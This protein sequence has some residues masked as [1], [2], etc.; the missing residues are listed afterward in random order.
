VAVKPNFS[1]P[2]RKAVTQTASCPVCGKAY[3]YVNN[4]KPPTCGATMCRLIR[5]DQS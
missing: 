4:H 1:D 5:K 3:T 2:D